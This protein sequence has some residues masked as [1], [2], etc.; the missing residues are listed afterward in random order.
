ML[1]H[2]EK[3]N[4]LFINSCVEKN[5]PSGWS[6]TFAFDCFFFFPMPLLLSIF[7]RANL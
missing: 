4:Y 3:Y 2:K 7:V 5:A 1:A 6:A